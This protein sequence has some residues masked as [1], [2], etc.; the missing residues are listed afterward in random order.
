MDHVYPVRYDEVQ[1][2]G[3]QKAAKRFNL[4]GRQK[5]QRQI[6]Q[7][8]MAFFGIINDPIAASSM[9]MLIE[10]RLKALKRPRKDAT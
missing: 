8:Y 7:L 5:A 9:T 3:L 6:N 1:Y 10:Q 2:N 4:T